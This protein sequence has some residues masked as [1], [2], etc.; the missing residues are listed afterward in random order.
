MPGA[1]DVSAREVAEGVLV[2]AIPMSPTLSTRSVALV[3]ETTTLVDAG[4]ADGAGALVGALARHGLP[5]VSDVVC[6][7]FH[8]DHTGGL[9]RLVQ[10]GGVEVH[11][12]VAECGF[13]IRP[14]LFGR[15]LRRAG[16]PAAIPAAAGV[17]EV[18]GV[19]DGQPFP[20]GGREW[21]ALHVPGHTWGHLAMWRAAD[22]VLVAGDAVQGT[23]VP[24]AGVPGQGTG[25]PYYVDVTAYRRSLDRM[26]ALAPEVLVLAHENPAWEGTV[27]DRADAADA[28]ARSTAEV[29]RID[30]LVRD[31][32]GS[33]ARSAS[34]IAARV[35]A[36]FG[37]AA[38]PQAE[39]TVRAHLA[40]IDR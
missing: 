18:S 30:A 32:V 10:G 38:T 20:V 36:E 23:G 25:I 3:G 21:T 24:F 13:V 6:T 5:R 28:L 19:L 26:A 2:L 37:A 16:I 27:L 17:P 12:H 33:G 1:G 8:H 34:E 15:A 11:A 22:R 29:E 14:D 9:E 31:A 40:A 35:C 4:T 7:H 39:V